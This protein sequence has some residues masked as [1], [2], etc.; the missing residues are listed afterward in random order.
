MT[1][2]NEIDLAPRCL[3]CGGPLTYVGF[4]ESECE[5]CGINGRRHRDW[6]ET[7]IY[8]ESHLTHCE[9]Q[10]DGTLRALHA[11][12]PQW[13]ASVMLGDSTIVVEPVATRAAALE[14]LERRVEEMRRHPT[15][16]VSREHVPRAPGHSRVTPMDEI[17]IVH[18]SNLPQDC[19]D[20]VD[21]R[22]VQKGWWRTNGGRA[23]CGVGWAFGALGCQRNATWQRSEYGVPV[24][25]CDRH[26][27]RVETEPEPDTWRGARGTK[28]DP[29]PINGFEDAAALRERGFHYQEW[30]RLPLL[31]TR[32][33]RDILCTILAEPQLMGAHL[34]G[35]QAGWLNGD[36][37]RVDLGRDG[38]W[39]LSLSLELDSILVENCEIPF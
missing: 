36:R 10:P 33:L 2:T 21:E 6:R 11:S 5:R 34:V 17:P 18:P 16:V 12:E 27:P 39:E 25:R 31:S 38:S 3:H 9:L 14:A 22:P 1:E 7:V 29:F 20:P 26:V 37:W 30:A 24:Q 15:I 23:R 35:T 8:T 4:T 28:G 13:R 32:V 19:E